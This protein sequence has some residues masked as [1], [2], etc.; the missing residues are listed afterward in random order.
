M[1]HTQPSKQT[2]IKRPIQ[3]NTNHNKQSI[4]QSNKQSKTDIT[5]TKN[6]KQA[7]KEGNQPTTKQTTKQSNTKQHQTEQA[8]KPITQA[9]NPKHTN[10][11][12]PNTQ[13]AERI[14][15][16]HTSNQT[17]QTNCQ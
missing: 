17:T 11:K 13:P 2:T 4:N 12:Q 8:Q 15:H 5:N 1:K 14:T 6:T 10:N 7:I 16:N 3:Q 9:V